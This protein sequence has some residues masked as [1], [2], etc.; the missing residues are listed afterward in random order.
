MV[1]TNNVTTSRS[2]HSACLENGLTEA[3]LLEAIAWVRRHERNGLSH[4]ECFC[5]HSGHRYL[6]VYDDRRE[7]AFI[8]GRQDGRCFADHQ[9]TFSTLAEGDTGTDVL[10]ALERLYQN[11]QNSNKA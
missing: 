9:W 1:I 3:E 8:F 6:C 11:R 4:C 5:D 2:T 7:E 10:A